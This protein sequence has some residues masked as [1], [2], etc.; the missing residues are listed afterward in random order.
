MPSVG[1]LNKV[2][3]RSKI[4]FYFFKKVIFNVGIAL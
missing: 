3:K 1:Y 4:T 2:R